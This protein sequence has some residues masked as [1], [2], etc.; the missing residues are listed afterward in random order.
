M[1]K[2]SGTTSSSVS[3]HG[4]DSFISW[5]KLNVNL[6]LMK[7]AMC[8]PV[9]STEV[10]PSWGELLFL[11]KKLVLQ[12]PFST[13]WFSAHF[14]VLPP[15]EGWKALPWFCRRGV[16]NWDLCSSCYNAYLSCKKFEISWEMQVLQQQE[17]ITLTWTF[18][19]VF[20]GGRVC[21]FHVFPPLKLA[22][23][24]SCDCCLWR[25]HV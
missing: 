8:S 1:R 5:G 14:Q 9:P 18:T 24:K 12:A 25:I 3:Q 11:G 17:R 4:A 7:P 22:V 2:G 6:L 20:W 21:G 16:R 19:E 13:P 23:S 10:R 15:Q